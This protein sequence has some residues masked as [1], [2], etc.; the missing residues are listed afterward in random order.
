MPSTQGGADPARIATAFHAYLTAE[1]YAVSAGQL[2][3]NLAAKMN[4]AS[5]LSD[6]PSLLRPG[7]VYD[8]GEAHG[9]VGRALLTRL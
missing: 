9:L 6:V 1:G 7:V 4:D 2:R 3:Q 8:A 5:F